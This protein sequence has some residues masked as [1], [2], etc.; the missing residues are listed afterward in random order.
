MSDTQS[1]PF[2]SVGNPS[3][4][5]KKFQL[6][7]LTISEK[8][9]KQWG[10]E[11]AKKIDI[12]ING[13]TSSYFFNRNNRWKRNRNYANGRVDM[14]KFVDLLQFNGKDN[15]INLNWQCVHIVNRIISGL[16]GR[17]KTRNEKVLVT[18]TDSLSVKQKKEEYEH[19][20][21]II[22]N[23]RQLERLEQEAGVQLIPRDKEIPSDREELNLWQSQFQRTPEEILYELGCNDV[24]ASC[25]WFD[26]LKEKMLH[27]SA[28]VGFVGTYTWMDDDG[29]IHV[30]WVK[31]EN[32]IY[33][34]SNYPDF[35][36][37]S[38]R[39]RLTTY[40]I[41]ELRRKYGKEFGGDLD[42]AQLF[43]LA[44]SAKEYQLY[45]QLT[46][47]NMWNVTFTRPY[48]EWNV[49]VLEFELKTVDS[50]SY[51]KTTTKKNKST[52]LRKGRPD[53]VDDNQ[54]VLDDT[55]INIYRG[56]FARQ[57]QMML[58]W[59]IKR[60]MI[61]PQ[62]PKE[63]GNAEFSYSFYM[64]QNYDM[65][66]LAIPE[67]IEEPADQ[68]ILARLKIQQLVMKM[69][70]HGSLVNWE[71]LQNIDYGLGDA[72][73]TIDVKKLFDQTGDLYYR[74]TDAEGRQIPVPVTELANAGFLPQLQGLIELYRFHYEVL[75]DELGE[76]PNLITQAAQPRVA[77]Q[78]I[79]TSQIQAEYATDYLYHAY[80]ACMADTARKISCL[81]KNSVTY[82]A[83]AYRHIMNQED[84]AGRIFSTKI[85]FLPTASDVARFEAILSQAMNTT[86]ELSLFVDPFQL[87]RVAKE[88][89]K[90]AEVMY[91]QATKKMLI[92]QQ[93]TAQ[94]NAQQTIEG[95]IASAQEA[96]K[97]KQQ[98]E[99]LKGE[100]SIKEKQVTGE[101]QNRTSIINM[102]T[103]WLT[104][105]TDGA[106]GE[107]PAEY[108][109]LVQAV[110]ENIMVSA[111]VDT[112][113][114]K[115]SVLDQMRL[116][117]EQQQAPPQQEQTQQQVA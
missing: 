105:K 38:W 31:P 69:R 60:N 97:A 52:I 26:V 42:E 71:A 10:L 15:Y 108:K 36:D 109:P 17:W 41:S 81:L 24:L 67:K 33:S 86:P 104:P 79:E 114:Q 65:T 99:A 110:M 59:G 30:E 25:G 46:W 85:Q 72:N 2:D 73:K 4:A 62:D 100:I 40:K 66:N 89:V 64:P 96:E 35:R 53:K 78:N 101:A 23:R 3:E 6:E 112:E 12:T 92:H 37:T 61:R 113:E 9:Q 58:E 63:I 19:L 48:D 21:F 13:G 83:K 8:S 90:A 115:K 54:E 111:V 56:V 74:G 70:P 87:L 11:L 22:D 93:S 107:V 45:D 27:D 14:N 116:A 75:K 84:I 32:A 57:T 29:I 117:R 39:G 95:Q 18:A 49:D 55:K 51:T 68:M 5:L 102:V 91:R 28:E 50:D 106:A 16:V 98:T 80:S 34:Y 20:E 47:M 43:T 94:A 77:V 7:N 44:Q 103:A 82:G 76:D 1:Q 88:D